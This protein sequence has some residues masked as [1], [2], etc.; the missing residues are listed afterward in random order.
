MA[1]CGFAAFLFARFP[2]IPIGAPRRPRMLAE[3]AKP[4]VLST[5]AAMLALRLAAPPSPVPKL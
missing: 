5:P 1:A 3:L 4:A 2:A